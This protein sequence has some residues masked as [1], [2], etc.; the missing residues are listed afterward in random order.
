MR[1]DRRVTKPIPIVVDSRLRVRADLLSE[2][3]L[4]RLREEFTHDNPDHARDK[5]RRSTRRGR[6]ARGPLPE[7]TIRTYVEDGGEISFPR[8][9][10]SRVREILKEFEIEHATLDRRAD[11]F[12]PRPVGLRLAPSI[13]PIAFQDEM[14]EAA[15]RT[16]NCIL[17]AAT[18]AGKTIVAEKLIVALGLCTLIIVPTKRIFDQ[19]IGRLG[20]ELGLRPSEIGTIRGKR[21]KIRAVNVAM[22]QTFGKRVEEFAGAFGVVIFDEVHRAAART[23]YPAVDACD[24]RYR[25]GMSDDERRKDRLQF[26]NYDLFGRVAYEADRK[27]LVRDGVILETEVRLVPTG[28]EAPWYSELPPEEKADEGH[29]GRLVEEMARDEERERLAAELIAEQMRDGHPTLAFSHRVEHC[30]RVRAAIVA[31]DPRVGVIVGDGG[32]ARE[33]DDTLAGIREGRILAAVGTYQSI[34]TGVDIP[35]VDRLVAL[36]PIHNNKTFFGQAR[37]RGCRV[38]RAPG[39]RKKDSIMYVLWDCAVHGLAPLRAYL[40]FNGGNV[41]VRRP[42]GSLQDG[43]EHL[44]AAEDELDAVREEGL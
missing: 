13:V 37:G 20:R 26:L 2:E 25:I 27:R 22:V 42:D 14:V 10:L 7:E 9:G 8:G 33:S 32:F 16:Q 28:F 39:A 36:T 23:Y 3:A 24:A 15:K 4:A 6:F 31:R 41:K 34:G 5:R 29:F 44:R 11:G 40:R 19:W 43:R 18:G 21:P 35:A 12:G 1:H 38:D 17:R 30:A